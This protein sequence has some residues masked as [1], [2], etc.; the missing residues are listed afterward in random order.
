MR[1]LLAL[2]F[3]VIFISGCQSS[4][5]LYEVSDMP[6]KEEKD[7]LKGQVPVPFF[8][9]SQQIISL[10]MNG[11]AFNTVGEWFDDESILYIVDKDGG[12]DLYY[13][14]LFSGEKKLFYHTD[15]P[16]V[17]MKANEDHS[18]F[19]IH[20]S[21]E[22]NEAEFLVVNKEGEKVYDWKINSFDLQFVWNPN[23]L[24]EV[25]VTAFLED[26]SFSTFVIKIGEETVTPYTVNEPFV[27]WFDKQSIAFMKWNQ[28]EPVF[29]APLYTF[30]FE[31]NKESLLMED[32]ISFTTFKDVLFTVSNDKVQTTKGIYRLYD[33]GTM[34]K[35]KEIMVPLLT[36]Y[37][38]WYVPYHDYVTNQKKFYTL[39]PDES[40][41]YDTYTGKFELI[42]FSLDAEE[43]ETILSNVDS[44][45]INFSP[46]GYY[47]LYGYQFENVIDVKEKEVKELIQL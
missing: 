31:T 3:T 14:H 26:W 12:S 17:T 22:R 36:T 40:A 10:D 6:Y 21:S 5:Q 27:Q 39:L 20:S 24:D 37:S 4:H 33:T 23:V 42:A 8:S 47:C 32:V 43:S 28:E 25:F 35:K 41:S 19:L 44:L 45:P 1:V 30:N 2:L 34:N 16:I 15:S 18:L 9:T 29:S 46:N 7:V 13:Y 11:E 38:R